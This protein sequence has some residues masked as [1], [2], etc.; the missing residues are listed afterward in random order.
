MTGNSARVWIPVAGSF[1]VYLIPLAGP[2]AIWL[3]GESL[4]QGL[5]RN[6]NVSWFVTEV[7]LALVAQIGVGALLAWSIR[8]S[9]LRLL[10]WFAAIPVLVAGINVAVL[11]AIPSH[12]LIE[13]DTA[14]EVSGWEE[15]CFVRDAGLMPI[16]TTAAQPP[17]G[18]SVW[19]MQRPPDGRYALLRLPDCVLTDAVL[20]T[21]TVQPGGRVDFMFGLQFTA[22]GGAATAER[23]VPATSERSWWLLASPSAALVPIEPPDFVDGAPILSDAAD[24]VAWIQRGEGSAPQP[25]RVVLRRLDASS[26]GD[27]IVELEPSGRASYTLLGVD[28][29]TSEVLLWRN[30]RP[31]LVRF[32][33]ESRDAGFTPD[34]IRAQASTYLRAR[35]GWV[36]WDAYKEEDPYQLAWSFPAGSGTHRTNRGRS[37]TAAAVDPTGSFVAISETTTLSIGDARDVVY[38]LRTRDGADVFRV[39]LPRYSRSHVVFFEGG[40]FAY[41]DPTGTHVLKIAN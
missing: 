11:V 36:A 4:M 29:V 17:A 33:G 34:V 27:R 6:R 20:P 23:Y 26:G 37:I 15:H 40:L 12:F 24:A 32:D 13:P 10:A 3:L 21:P 22:P 19:W 2:H 9:R 30:D 8:G 39:Y 18:A 25:Q 1:G 7:A 31:V 41:S 28:T 35:D 16:R 14:P 38:V 5:M